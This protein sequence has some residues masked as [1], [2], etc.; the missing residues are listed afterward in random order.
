MKLSILIPVYNEASTIEEVLHQVRAVP[1]PGITKEIIVVDDGSTDATPEILR[2]EK[3]HASEVTVYTSPRNF[4]KGQAIRTGLP[5]ATGD[6]I[7][8]QDADLEVNPQE[9][10]R[11]LEPIQ[12]EKASVVYGSRFL[13]LRNPIPWRSRFARWVLTTL[14]NLLYGSHLTDEATAYKVFRAEV[15]KRVSLECV[16]FEFCPE[17]TAKVLR[18]GHRI[19]EIPISYRPRSKAEGKKLRYWRDGLIA[20]YT[21]LRYR[22]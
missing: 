1:L 4:G 18:Q 14:A 5:H 7:L 19:V 3:E 8:I 16:G 21:L 17:V 10:S 6:V 12:Q 9:Y 22:M 13:T 2:R 20:V 15:L 11:L